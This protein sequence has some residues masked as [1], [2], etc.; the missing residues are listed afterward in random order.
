[1]II[2]CTTDP[3]VVWQNSLS[4]VD[5]CIKAGVLID[6]FVYPGHDHNVAGPDRAHLVK[7]IE[8]YYKRNL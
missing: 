8:D 1:M 7:K 2:H 6:Y 4:F 5:A 3:V